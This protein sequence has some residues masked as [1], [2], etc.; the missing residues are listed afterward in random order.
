MLPFYM[1]Q[2]NIFTGIISRWQD[3]TMTSPVAADMAIHRTQTRA[4]QLSALANCC[5]IHCIFWPVNV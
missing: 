1:G 2:E 3:S 4:D 5:W